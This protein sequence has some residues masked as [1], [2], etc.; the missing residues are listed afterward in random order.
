[1]YGSENWA[2]QK[3]NESRLTKRIYRANVC[4]GKV[5][6]GRPGKSYADHVGGILKKGQILSARNRRACRK[7]L[8]DVEA[9]TREEK[10]PE[11][12]AYAAIAEIAVTA[13]PSFAGLL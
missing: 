10:Q 4:D 6:K 1:M 11:V 7:T 9:C 3:K 2:R 12:R 5:G 13:G 8:M